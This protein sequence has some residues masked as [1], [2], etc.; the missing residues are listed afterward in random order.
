VVECLP[1]KYEALSS[2]PKML[3][4]LTNF[5]ENLVVVAFYFWCLGKLVNFG[6][7]SKCRGCQVMVSTTKENKA[8]QER[9]NQVD[10]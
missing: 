4:C 8:G 10:C 2:N 1:S 9:W 5:V 3:F 6:Q 7:I